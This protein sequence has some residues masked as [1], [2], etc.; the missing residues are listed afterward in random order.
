MPYDTAQFKTTFEETPLPMSERIAFIGGGNMAASLIGGLLKAGHSPAQIAVAE[1]LAERSAWLQHEFPGVQL[2]T[3]ATAVVTGAR[4][5]VLAVKPQQMREALAN[6]ALDAGCVVVSIAAGVTLASLRRSLGGGVHLV[7]SMPN[8]PALLG[9]G[10]SGLYAEPSVPA[11]A[12]ALAERILRAA[13]DCVWLEQ[14]TQIDAVTALSGS[15]PAYFFLLTE[16]LREAGVQ[17]GLAPEVAARLARQTFVGSA[18]MAAGET[19]VQ[20][21]RAQVTSK[22]GTTQAALE[23]LEQAGLRK[24]FADA[25]RAAEARSRELG[26]LLSKES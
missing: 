26:A 23:H 7:R 11:A 9:A 4:A 25:L 13:G 24:L 8:T 20:Q 14:E 17:L 21:L 22:G 15:G 5:V 16:A 18:L 10:I 6:L 3:Q 19:D 12:R 2:G 1:P